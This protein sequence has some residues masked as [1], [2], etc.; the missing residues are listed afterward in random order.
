MQR[1]PSSCQLGSDI[2]FSNSFSDV[3]SV[4]FLPI[5]DSKGNEN[6]G[7]LGYDTILCVRK[8]TYIISLM[9]IGTVLKFSVLQ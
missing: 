1:F 8:L 9:V 2:F 6:V 5:S 3:I 7:I 4:M